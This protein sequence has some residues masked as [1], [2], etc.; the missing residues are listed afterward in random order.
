MVFRR[1]S[2][3]MVLL[4]CL[5][6]IM[7][8]ACTRVCAQAYCTSHSSMLCMHR[9]CCTTTSRTL[10]HCSARLAETWP[11]HDVGAHPAPSIGRHLAFDEE[12]N[13]AGK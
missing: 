4:N 11:L 5:I 8:D 1:F 13:G 12:L 7:A 3:S 6:A 9:A 10:V 2:M